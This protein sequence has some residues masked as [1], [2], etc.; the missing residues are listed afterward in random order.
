MSRGKGLRGARQSASPG[1][2]SG[3]GQSTHPGT[4]VGLGGDRCVRSPAARVAAGNTFTFGR[5]T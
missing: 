4:P 1:G 5:V 3:Y 2:G